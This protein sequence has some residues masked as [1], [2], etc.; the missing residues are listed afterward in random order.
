M[1]R[2]KMIAGVWGLGVASLLAVLIVLGSRSL[3]HFDAALVGY[4]FATLFAVF[5]ITYRYAM[6]LQRPPTHMY[7]WRGWQVFLRPRFV[8]TNLYELVRRFS[9]EF[10]ANR[11][12]FRRGKARWAAHWL[13]MWGCL[14]ASAITFPLVWGWIHFE[15]V[16]GRLDWYRT[17]VFG[18][19]VHDFPIVSPFGFLIFHG[20]VWAS[21]LVIAGVILAF[22]RRMID[23][24]AAAVQQFAED[25][26]PLVLLFAISVTGLML[27]ASYTWLKGYG[28][29]FL[30][31][32]H[33][34]TVIFTLLW[35]PFGKFFHIFQRPAQLGVSFYKDV[36]RQ[37]EQARCGRCGQPFASA[38][39][40]RDLMTV[41]RQ[42]GFSYEMQRPDAN[43]Y[44]QICP[45]CRRAMFGMAQ[46]VLWA[47]ARE[48]EAS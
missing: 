7:W 35:L 38:M 47:Q 44:Q 16:P 14:L 41:E 19:A 17:F 25:I 43:H 31:I 36:G 34:L 27:T 24:G 4:T 40:V 32:L 30:A 10:V 42:L 39:M 9:V 29:D 33:A 13:I 12:I 28:Y 46:G 11:F 18:F 3:E 6:W 1:T 2:A 21:F 26:L 8:V 15:S 37:S 5:G 22:R 20:L 48:K 45:R 23:H